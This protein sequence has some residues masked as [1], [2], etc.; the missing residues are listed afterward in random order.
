MVCAARHRAVL[1]QVV[2]RSYAVLSHLCTSETQLSPAAWVPA[3][4][5][6][7]EGFQCGDGRRTFPLAFTQKYW[8]WGQWLLPKSCCRKRG[9]GEAMGCGK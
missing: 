6:G 9:P 7:T 4:S 5:L 1:A 3:R 2:L 8:P